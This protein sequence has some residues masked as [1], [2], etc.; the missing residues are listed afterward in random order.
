MNKSAFTLM[1]L[2][3]VISIISLL[4]SLV[5]INSKYMINK[6]RDTQVMDTVGKVR[7]AIAAHLAVKGSLPENLGQLVP[8]FIRNMPT[9][10]NGSNAKLTI[11]YD[12]KKGTV[13]LVVSQGE[14]ADFLGRN[15]EDY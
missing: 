9:S 2:L 6:A 12:N 5:G 7:S 8:E 13:W 15:Y 10:L 4:A 3:V 1:E 14:S 11:D